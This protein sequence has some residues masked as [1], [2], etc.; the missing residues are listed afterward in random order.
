LI[1]I[2]YTSM[3][4]VDASVLHS[5]L[6]AK[7]R[8]RHM[9]VFVRLAELQNLRHTA[10]ALGLSQPA[11][12][13]VLADMERLVD[14][15]LFERHAR[16]VRITPAGAALLPLAQRI[17]ELLAE[18]SEALTSMRRKGEG[19]V[20]VASITS[21]IAGLLV[22]AIPTFA[23]AHP[24]IQLHVVECHVDQWGLML[25]RREVDVAVCR[26][27]A[28]SLAGY[29]FLPLTPDR[30]VVACGTAH[31]LAGRRAVAWSRLAR[32]TWLPAPVGSTARTVFD[33]CMA[34]AGVAPR[35]CQV[36][37]R[38]SALTWSLLNADRLVTLVPFG[39]VRQLVEAGQLATIE[40]ATSLTFSP[41]G[42][43]VPE[44]GGSAATRRFVEH[45]VRIASP[46]PERRT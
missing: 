15:A 13:Q 44:D 5:R 26:A 43:M 38:V 35:L 14:V 34:D 1:A 23:H 9:Q 33:R 21:G 28:A 19:V 12:S 41:I 24:S 11:V 29:R 39:V 40:P 30:F 3:D 7:A 17:L 18:G 2:A 8:L 36:I 27:P 31:P 32:E 45:L 46:A 37:T 20:R 10:D 25:A 22:R 6:Q 42:V 4:H 16:G